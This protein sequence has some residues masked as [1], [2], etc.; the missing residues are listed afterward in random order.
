V[1][2]DG[3]VYYTQFTPYEIRK[4]APDGTLVLTIHRENDYRPPRIECYDDGLEFYN[5]AGSYRI[6]VAS[7]GRFM[8]AVHL[9]A[10]DHQPSGT[11]VDLFDADGRLLASHQLGRWT[12]IYCLDGKDR[13]IASEGHNV[14]VRYRLNFN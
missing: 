11:L 12:S 10:D 14:L 8:N 1:D 3:F 9:I 13:I 7:D 5:Y 6:L 4:F 2:R